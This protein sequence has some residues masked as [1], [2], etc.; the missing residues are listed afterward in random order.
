MVESGSDS[1]STYTD[2]KS[3]VWK[4][5]QVK[6]FIHKLGFLECNEEQKEKLD[7]FMSVTE[8]SYYAF[9]KIRMIVLLTKMHV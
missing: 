1:K 4:E 9:T 3:I 2:S 8:V 5:E 6:D 7:T